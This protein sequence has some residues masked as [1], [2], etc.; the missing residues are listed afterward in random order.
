MDTFNLLS[1]IV[2]IVFVISFIV[3]PRAGTTTN[4][5]IEANDGS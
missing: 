1:T 4:K 2:L 3:C 5:D